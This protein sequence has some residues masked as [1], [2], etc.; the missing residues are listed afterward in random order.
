MFKKNAN[1]YPWKPLLIIHIHADNFNLKIYY[2]LDFSDSCI[3][4]KRNF[5]DILRSIAR[6]HA[7]AEQFFKIN[8]RK[9]IKLPFIIMRRRENET[10]LINLLC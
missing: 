7:T 4:N 8:L 1:L 5:D 2:E 10:N 3:S 6:D 9:L